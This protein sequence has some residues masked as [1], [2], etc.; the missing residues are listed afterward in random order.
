[1]IDGNTME[2]LIKVTQGIKGWLFRNPARL[3]TVLTSVFGLAFVLLVPPFQIP[4]ELTHLTRSYELS[5]LH[6]AQVK[7]AGTTDR[8]GTYL[9]TSIVKTFD[10][11]TMRLKP[12]DLDVAQARKYSHAQT[13]AAL[14]IPLDL[15]N[16]TFFDTGSSPAYFPLLYVPQALTIKFLELFNT[17][18]IVMLY[19]TRFVGLVIW[20]VLVRFALNIVRARRYQV[21]LVGVLL[22]P[23]FVAQPSASTDPL[24]N[25]LLVVFLALVANALISKNEISTR[26]MLLLIGLVSLMTLSKPVYAVFGAMLLLLPLPYIRFKTILYRLVVFTTPFI[27]FIAW[28]LLTRRGGGPYYVDSIAI[29]GAMPSL[30]AQYVIPNV[31]NFVQP[32]VNSFLLG[33]SDYIYVSVIGLFGKLDTPLPTV[34]V[35]LGYLVIVLAVFARSEGGKPPRAY[36][37]ALSQKKVIVAIVLTS[38]TYIGGVYLAMYINSTPYQEKIVTGVQGRYFLPLIPL[39]VLFVS[40]NFVIVKQSLYN[41]L[42]LG[43]PALL[44]VVSVII[45]VLRYYVVYP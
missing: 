7:E 9:P 31:F 13:K 20:I 11:T 25:G 16:K 45:L 1:M 18:I 28:A 34:F 6:V 19:A 15:S 33:W 3:F 30:Q 37:R 43:L 38:L 42:V 12:G 32:F 35:L 36:V 40:K 41:A 21:P 44:L 10:I 39:A 17:P 29:S 24:I 4:D 26:Q 27:V 8:L 23:M 22:L 5:G 14:S 2:K